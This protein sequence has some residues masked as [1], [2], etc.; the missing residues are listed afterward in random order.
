M[1]N[2]DLENSLRAEIESYV[3]SRMSGLKEEVEQLR[4]QLDEALARISERAGEP[5]GVVAGGVR[6]GKI[7]RGH[8]SGRDRR[9]ASG[10]SPQ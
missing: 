9:G 5:V 10:Q 3:S 2:G 6:P 8:G 1:S 4:A 7:A